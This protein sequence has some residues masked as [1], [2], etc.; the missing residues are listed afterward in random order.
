[1]FAGWSTQLRRGCWVATGFSRQG[2]P[3]PQGTELDEESVNPA[4]M[5]LRPGYH[6]HANISSKAVCLGQVIQQQQNWLND[7]KII[8]ILLRDGTATAESKLVVAPLHCPETTWKHNSSSPEQVQTKE[9]NIHKTD[10]NKIKWYSQNRY[11]QS[12]TIFMTWLT[13][14]VEWHKKFNFILLILCSFI[15]HLTEKMGNMLI[16]TSI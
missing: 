8:C 12:K 5:K 9:N 10:A 2:A 1:M 4:K 14:V 16:C 6:I 7:Q 3:I 11:K 13:T 15:I